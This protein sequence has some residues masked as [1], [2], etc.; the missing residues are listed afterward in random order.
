MYVPCY[1]ENRLLISPYSD[2]SD[3]VYALSLP[4]IYTDLA[5]FTNDQIGKLN[6]FI[7]DSTDDVEF[8]SILD[9]N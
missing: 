4:R 6:S 7:R 8:S 3:S 9:D 1:D 5:Y 2:K